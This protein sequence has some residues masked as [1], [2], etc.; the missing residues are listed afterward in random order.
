[1][2]AK[3][4]RTEE[5]ADRLVK[6]LSV[7][8]LLLFIPALVIMNYGAVSSDRGIFAFSLLLALVA[9]VAGGWAIKVKTGTMILGVIGAA[10]LYVAAAL[11]FVVSI[12]L[13]S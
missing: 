9:A 2:K 8:S 12:L 3:R 10:L 11:I 7:V 13:T 1:M 6:Q 5:E 4:S